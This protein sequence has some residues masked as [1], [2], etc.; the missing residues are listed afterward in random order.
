MEWRSVGV[1]GS[2]SLHVS[3]LPFSVDCR[4]LAAFIRMDDIWVISWVEY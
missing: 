4:L 2:F 1:S 3:L